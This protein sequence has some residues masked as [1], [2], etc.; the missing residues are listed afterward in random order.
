M[1]KCIK[2]RREKIKEDTKPI[3]IF[4]K[5]Q[6]M[7]VIYSFKKALFVFNGLIYNG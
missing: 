7:G 4:K 1:Q 3:V 6:Q 2:R 5:W